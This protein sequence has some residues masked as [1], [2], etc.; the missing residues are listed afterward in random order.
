MFLYSS[1][2]SVKSIVMSMF[3]GSIMSQ[4][5]VCFFNL[6]LCHSNQTCSQAMLERIK[7]T[8]TGLA[9]FH[10]SKLLNMIRS[11]CHLLPSCPTGNLTTTEEQNMKNC[12]PGDWFIFSKMF[13]HSYCTKSHVIMWTLITCV[14]YSQSSH[15][16]AAAPKSG[17]KPCL[18]VIILH[19]GG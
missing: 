2:I 12:Y 7:N 13:H 1:C 5:I 14:V 6:E 16:A 18:T 3:A 19:K 10:T 4:L 17:T 8:F 11:T 15:S 9:K